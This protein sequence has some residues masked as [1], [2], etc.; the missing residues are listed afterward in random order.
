M[1]RILAKSNLLPRDSDWIRSN[2]ICLEKIRPGQSTIPDAGR[3]AFAQMLIEA[4]DIVVPVPLLNIPNKDSLV[5][6]PSEINAGGERVK[7]DGKPIGHQLI[8]NYCF[9]HQE[10][11]LILCPQTNAI[12]INHCSNRHKENQ[13]NNGNGPNARVQWANGWDPTN[14]EWLQK[15]MEEIKNLTAK[16]Q[17]GLSFEIIATTD[18]APGEEVRIIMTIALRV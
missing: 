9:G 6:Y 4:G 11:K 17:R 16:G 13:C 18:I 8:M 2:G 1:T 15:S 3:G 7:I 5:M 14:E 10:S 12:L